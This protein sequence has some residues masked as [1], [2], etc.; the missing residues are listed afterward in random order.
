MLQFHLSSAMQEKDIYK[1][2]VL[3]TI[4]GLIILFIC[5][6][7]LQLSPSS[8]LETA[9]PSQS[10]KLAGVVSKFNFQDKVAFLTIEGSQVTENEVIVFTDKPFFI[11]EGNYV[12]VTGTIEE[13]NGKKEL[14]A[15]EIV[16]K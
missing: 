11:E 10:L 8:S 15:S 9:K 4:I 13:Y 1:A 2:A 12:E 16:V 5:S 14:I 3:I 7:N 6:E